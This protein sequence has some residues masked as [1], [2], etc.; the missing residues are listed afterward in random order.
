MSA[1][2]KS[3]TLEQTCTGGPGE[4]AADPEVSII[5][6]VF[7]EAPNLKT[8][9]EDT[10]G[11]MRAEARPFELILVD[12]GSTDNGP[13]L[14]RVLK[15]QAP[16]LRVIFLR[17]N[18]GQSAAM[19][20]GF[21]HAR[22]DIVVT[23]DGDLQNDPR[24]LPRV[25]RT[26]DE[27]YDVVSGWRRD[28]K[29]PWLTRRLPSVAAN[30]IL[31]RVTNVKIHDFGCTLKG[32]RADFVRRLRLYSDMHRYIPGMAAAMGAR[33]KEIVVRHHPR[34][35]GKSKYGISR[36]IKVLSD[37][38]VL[39]LLIRFSAKPLHYFGLISL[40]IFVFALL[41]SFVA[42]FDTSKIMMVSYTTVIFP[43]IAVLGFFLGFHF[44]MIGLLCELVVE[45]GEESVEQLYRVETLSTEGP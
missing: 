44:L 34:R 7:N 38:I 12:D 25:V 8:L 11:V 41:M 6:P 10:L 5:V 31:A 20:A 33:V 19:T 4:E 1:N 23:M 39:R 28:R 42:F 36:A 26:L 30:W 18:F 3:R 9:V 16:E 22:G 27:G 24:D 2:P 17:R 29:D 43:T 15:T 21:D 35:Y 45:V 14:L 37:L 40:P 13:D 32:Y